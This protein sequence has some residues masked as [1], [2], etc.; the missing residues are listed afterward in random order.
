MNNKI[1]KTSIYEKQEQDDKF[2]NIYIYI[3]TLD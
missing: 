1:A 2:I 3:I